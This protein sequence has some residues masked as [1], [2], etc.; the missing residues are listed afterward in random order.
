[1]NLCILEDEIPKRED[2][3]IRKPVAS[4]SGTRE[5]LLILISFNRLVIYNVFLSRS[6]KCTSKVVTPDNKRT[7]AENTAS[8]SETA[9]ELDEDDNLKLKL[10]IH[11]FTIPSSYNQLLL[12]LMNKTL[13]I[14]SRS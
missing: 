14:Y 8:W 11:E 7:M 3:K 10:L 12:E 2:Y 4:D 13:A 1:M 9:Q 5:D 6:N